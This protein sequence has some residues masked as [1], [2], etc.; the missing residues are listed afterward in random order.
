MGLPGLLETSQTAERKSAILVFLRGTEKPRLAPKE[1]ARTWAPGRSQ[2]QPY[3]ANSS[4]LPATTT[5]AACPGVTLVAKDLP[6]SRSWKRTSV[7][8]SDSDVMTYRVAS[9]KRVGE[10]RMPGSATGV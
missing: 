7:G 2:F 4:P 5:I 8:S 1:R 9:R 3:L 6:L 10:I